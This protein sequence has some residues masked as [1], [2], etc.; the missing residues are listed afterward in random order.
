M[1][2]GGRAAENVPGADLEG[3][4]RLGALLAPAA[5]GKGEAQPPEYLLDVTN[6]RGPDGIFR[7][8]HA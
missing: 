7:V 5:G 6:R 3:R 2:T 1:A 4:L 8:L